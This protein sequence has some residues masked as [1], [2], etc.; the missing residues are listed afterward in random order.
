[1]GLLRGALHCLVLLERRLA[2]VHRAGA[3]SVKDPEAPA[4]HCINRISQRLK[5]WSMGD[6]GHVHSIKCS[7]SVS[8]PHQLP[9]TGAQAN[10]GMHDDTTVSTGGALTARRQR[11]RV[12][13]I[14]F[15]A[16]STALIFLSFG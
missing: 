9:S 10:A 8:H 14:S 7:F 2:Q 11:R 6:T 4:L 3:T 15:G 12:R 13:V 5:L 1:M 16:I